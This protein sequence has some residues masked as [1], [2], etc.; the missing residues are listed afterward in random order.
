M[1]KKNLTAN[2]GE[3]QEHGFNLWGQETFE[4]E[5]TTH[6]SILA[7]SLMDRGAWQAGSLSAD[8]LG[9]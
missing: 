9:H 1:V 3:S 7:R 6:S 5:M 2:A 8:Y 4:V